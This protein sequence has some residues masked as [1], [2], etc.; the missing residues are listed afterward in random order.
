MYYILPGIF[1]IKKPYPLYNRYDFCPPDILHTI[2]GG[3]LKDFIFNTCVVV[4]EL[5]TL[6]RGRYRNSLTLLNEMVRNFPVGQTAAY[7]LKRFHE[8]VTPYVVNKK[9]SKKKSN[10]NPNIQF[11]TIHMQYLITHIRFFNK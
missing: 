3:Y 1:R 2:L 10:K 8:G 5:K 6:E 11:F 9:G 7:G 4:N